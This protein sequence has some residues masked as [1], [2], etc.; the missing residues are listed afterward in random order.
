M[1]DP[2]LPYEVIETGDNP[3]VCIIWLHGLGADGHDFVPLVPQL[4]LPDAPAIRFI[5][6]HAPSIP[7][8]I[9]GGMVMPGWYDIRTAEFTQREDASGI[10]QSQAQIT[11]L[12]V[13]ENNRGI[14]TDHIFLAGFSQ[15]GAVCL[16]TGLRYPEHLAGIIALSTYLPLQGSASTEISDQN[17]S[18]VIF[19]AHGIQDPIVPLSTAERSKQWLMD[20]SYPVTWNTYPMQHNVSQ[21]E[22]NDLSKWLTMLL[23]EV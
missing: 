15:G 8:T 19:M 18:T 2:V 5:F 10:I 13:Q 23:Q 20:N 7:I 1:D 22:I 14:A 21:D 16:Y 6:P 12:I 3:A 4:K 17:R 9:N 11:R